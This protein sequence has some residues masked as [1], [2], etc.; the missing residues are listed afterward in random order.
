MNL[1]HYREVGFEQVAYMTKDSS[2]GKKKHNVYVNYLFDYDPRGKKGVYIIAKA[3]DVLK[4]GET[5]DLKDRF[6]CYESHS[7]AT[8][9]RIRE[10]MEEILNYS[11]YF[12]ECPSYKVGFAGVQVD[13]GI[14]YKDLEKQLLRQYK[15]TNGN[16]PIWNKG[17]Q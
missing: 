15:E 14:R 16:V 3:D 10:A 17:I 2:L 9:V 1:E 12:I 13:Q 11:I 6:S 5:E 8:N 7:G 4:I